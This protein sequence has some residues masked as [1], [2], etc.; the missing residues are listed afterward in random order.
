MPGMDGW[1]LARRLH[2]LPPARR[3]LLVAMTGCD[4]AGD[5]RRALEAGIDLYLVKPVGLETLVVVL[6]RFWRVITPHPVT[7]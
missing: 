4:G 1:E 7:G 6:E 2:P 5:R 3:P